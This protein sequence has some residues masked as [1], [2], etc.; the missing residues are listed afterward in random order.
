MMINDFFSILSRKF[1]FDQ[2]FIS[3]KVNQEKPK[4]YTWRRPLGLSALG[5]S[6]R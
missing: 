3:T 2:S 1:T 4:C 5:W 6:Y